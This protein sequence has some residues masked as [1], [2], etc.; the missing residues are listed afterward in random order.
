MKDYLIVAVLVGH[1]TYQDLKILLCSTQLGTFMWN[2]IIPSQGIWIF[3]QCALLLI[4]SAI[5]KD[6][7]P[8]VCMWHFFACGRSLSHCSGLS[9]LLSSSSGSP[10]SSNHLSAFICAAHLPHCDG[11]EHILR[12]CLYHP[13]IQVLPRQLQLQQIFDV[14]VASMLRISCACRIMLFRFIKSAT[15]FFFFFLN[16]SHTPICFSV[17]F[18]SKKKK[19]KKKRN[20]PCSVVVWNRGTHE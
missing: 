5:L 11:A 9:R 16:L 17:L 2:A 14:L 8:S 18:Y 7:F 1:T 6:F 10:K 20:R 13:N 15:F 3:Y 19:K 4:A 12:L